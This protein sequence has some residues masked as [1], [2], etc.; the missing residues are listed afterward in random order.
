MMGLDWP[1]EVR[2]GEKE[3]K[4]EKKRGG[5]EGTGQRVERGLCF[6]SCHGT[7]LPLAG[8]VMWW[9]LSLVFMPFSPSPIC[10]ATAASL[11]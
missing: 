8:D 6:F 3:A 5:C 7:R 2:R 11:L 10:H 1:P 4:K 9:S